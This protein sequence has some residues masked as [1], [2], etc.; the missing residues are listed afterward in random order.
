MIW[1]NNMSKCSEPKIEVFN[2][3]SDYTSVKFYPDFERFGIKELSKDMMD[4]M[5]KR[6][7]DLSGVISSNVKVFLNNK[8]L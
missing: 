5:K 1:E 6:V 2:G 4:L 8:R 7:Y 3:S